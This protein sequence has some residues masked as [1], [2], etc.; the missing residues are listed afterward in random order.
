MLPRFWDPLVVGGGDGGYLVVQQ[1]VFDS[2][3]DEAL[4]NVS[5]AGHLKQL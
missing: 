1:P 5:E 4:A 3:T 2:S